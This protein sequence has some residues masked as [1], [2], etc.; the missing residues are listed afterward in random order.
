MENNNTIGM[1]S[2]KNIFQIHVAN[3][4]GQTQRTLGC[5]VTVAGSSV[6]YCAYA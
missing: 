3:L 1:D 5:L 4:E 2:A 6:D